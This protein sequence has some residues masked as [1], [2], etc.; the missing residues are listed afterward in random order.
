[1]DQVQLRIACNTSNSFPVKCG[2]GMER[3]RGAGGEGGAGKGKNYLSHA[4]VYVSHL[5]SGE[6]LF[7]AHFAPQILFN[8]FISHASVKE[9]SPGDICCHTCYSLTVV[10]LLFF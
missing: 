9:R 10:G 8:C 6:A 4:H 2:A 5:A 7:L 3:K 1:M